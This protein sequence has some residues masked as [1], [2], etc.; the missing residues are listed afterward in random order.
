MGFYKKE[1]ECLIYSYFYQLPLKGGCNMK[2]ISFEEMQEFAKN[3]E[4]EFIEYKE[5][6]IKPDVIAQYI[7][8]LSNSAALHGEPKAYMFW[9]ISDDRNIV[10]TKFY[11]YEIKINGGEPLIT[12]LEHSF[13][14]NVNFSFDEYTSR[15]YHI[16]ILSI[17]AA[18]T[19][20]IEFKGNEYIRSGSSLKSL[21]KYPEKEQKLWDIFRNAAFEDDIAK[22]NVS[23]DQMTDMLDVQTYFSFMHSHMPDNNDTTVD[24][25][26]R[27]G[28]ISLDNSMNISIT[29]LGAIAFAKRLDY[30]PSIQRHAVRVIRY[31]GI[32]KLVASN[33]LTGSKGYALGFSG[34]LKF[35]SEQI[36]K[37]EEYPDG[38]RKVISDFPDIAIREFVANA[39]IHQDFSI[40][41]AGPVI[42]IYD[43]RVVITNPGRPL[44]DIYRLMDMPAWS[45]NEKLASLFRKMNFIEERGS[46]IDKI[47]ITLES[48][49]LPAPRM[50]E[51]GEFFEATLFS[52][53]SFKDMDDEERSTAIYYHA[54]L[55]YLESDYL[56]NSSLRQRF[57]LRDNQSPAVT[58]SIAKAVD[59]GY[60]VAYDKNAGPK[61]MKYVPFWAKK[62]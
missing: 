41:G 4:S 26:V 29:N 35:I 47:I 25:L 50:L 21:K 30:F 32:N 51:K 34:L 36:P 2:E 28:I 10:G 48:E 17:S 52:R 45:R 43:N 13:T 54:S 24:Y 37:K 60:I 39:L 62:I 31:K 46:G 12:W 18:T 22:S 9:G 7:S 55:K 1:A 15:E 38:V 3:P 11:P 8:G 33:E 27:D 23:F 49:G 57:G 14:P 20:P 16:V 59:Q 40:T 58:K 56:T 42:E 19:A 53:K 6:N 44:N 61:S 5:N